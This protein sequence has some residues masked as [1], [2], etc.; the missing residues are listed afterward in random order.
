LRDK[1]R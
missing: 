1:Y